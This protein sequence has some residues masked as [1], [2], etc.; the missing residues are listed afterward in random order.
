MCVDSLSFCLDEL[1]DAR[2]YSHKH[3]LNLV[4]CISLLLSQCVFPFLLYPTPS[5][6]S[7]LSPGSLSL[8]SSLPPFSLFLSSLP[9]SL[10][11]HFLFSSSV[12]FPLFLPSLPFSLS[13]P[14]FSLVLSVSLFLLSHPFSLDLN[15]SSLVLSVSLCSP[16]S[17]FVSRSP[18]IFSRSCQFL[19]VSPF[20]LYL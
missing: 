10:N 2:T 14:L 7:R 20:S 13:I 11:F 19:S 12:C 6:L 8:S 4:L 16:F 18:F 3:S 17:P 15:F 9:S 5:F 1:T